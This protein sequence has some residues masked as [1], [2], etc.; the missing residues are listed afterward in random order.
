MDN[1]KWYGGIIVG[2][3]GFIYDIPHNAQTVLKIDPIDHG[4]RDSRGGEKWSFA[5]GE[6]ENGLEAGLTAGH[7]SIGFPNNAD[8]IVVI[9]C[10]KKKKKKTSIVYYTIGSSDSLKGGRHR[11]PHDGR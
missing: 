9:D 5:L 2:S 6:I 3:N 4:S 7:K 10:E 8:Q 1:K 11:I